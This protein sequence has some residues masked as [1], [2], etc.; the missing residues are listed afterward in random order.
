MIPYTARTTLLSGI[1]GTF[2]HEGPKR[3]LS[4]RIDGTATEANCRFGHAFTFVD[5]DSDAV[6]PGGEGVFAGIMVHPHAYAID[7]DIAMPGSISEFA[8]MGYVNVAIADDAVIRGARVGYLPT[9]GALVI[10]G[11]T[12]ADDA[13]EIIG[14]TVS[15][16][17]ASPEKDAEN[18]VLAVITLNG[19]QPIPAPADPGTGG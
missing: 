6:V 5:A 13:I 4:A 19:E 17:P 8:Q 3:A 10:M 18:R 1:P 7:R 15:R 16:H 14:A 12:G 11:S 2:S 9:T